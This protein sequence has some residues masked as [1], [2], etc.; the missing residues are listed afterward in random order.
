MPTI[1]RARIV[2]KHMGGSIYYDPAHGC[3]RVIQINSRSLMFNH[4]KLIE[5]SY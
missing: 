1:E 4:Y 5:G 2:Q 3:Y